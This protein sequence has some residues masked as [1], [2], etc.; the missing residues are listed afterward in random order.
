MAAHDL[1]IRTIDAYDTIGKSPYFRTAAVDRSIVDGPVVYVNN[2]LEGNLFDDSGTGKVLFGPG[3][4]HPNFNF[5]STIGS[6][7]ASVD[8]TSLSRANGIVTIG[9]TSHGLSTNDLF[10][11]EGV[12]LDSTHDYEFNGVYKV[13]QKIDNDQFTFVKK[14]QDFSGTYYS[15]PITVTLWKYSSSEPALSIF[16]NRQPA[17]ASGLS[18]SSILISPKILTDSKTRRRVSTG[19][20]YIRFNIADSTGLLGGLNT[21][22]FNVIDVTTN[23]NVKP[24]IWAW[25]FGGIT[26]VADGNFLTADRNPNNNLDTI[27]NSYAVVLRPTGEGSY[28]EFALVKFNW[29][30]ITSANWFTNFIDTALI[31]KYSNVG[32][33]DLGYL[34]STNPNVAQISG[35]QKVVEITKSSSF[36][37]DSEQPLKFNLKIS[38]RKHLLSDQSTD[39]SYYFQLATS[40]DYN[41]FGDAALYSNIM[42]SYIKRPRTNGLTV[43]TFQ[44]AGYVNVV[45]SDLGKNVVVAANSVGTLSWYDNTT[46]TWWIKDVA[47]A[48]PSGSAITINTGI[49]AGTS[50]IN[51][52]F[53]S[54][55]R[56][57]NP[58]NSDSTDQRNYLLLPW[59]YFKFINLSPTGYVSGSSTIKIDNLL[60]RQMNADDKLYF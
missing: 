34:I 4:I 50:N 7:P 56:Y 3:T 58:I 18:Y 1:L 8:V 11:I 23:E 27:F 44:V 17:D 51:S 38:V 48:I 24:I 9:V 40:S 32:G 2:S 22:I 52:Y 54:G 16:D 14:G 31:N 33:V 60:F 12:P 25:F 47:S 41:S 45:S 15:Y 59:I 29:G 5:I 35:V 57:I 42:H 20:L 39:N 6:P 55:L 28:L 10:S 30:E 46:R 43:T 36:L 19:D 49:G 26:K 37:Y 13:F 53:D 21:N